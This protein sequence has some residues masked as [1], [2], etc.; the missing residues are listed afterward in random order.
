MRFQQEKTKTWK[1]ELDIIKLIS[2][3]ATGITQHA[4]IHLQKRKIEAI[5]PVTGKTVLLNI[6]VISQDGV[7]FVNITEMVQYS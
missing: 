6:K 7:Y 4:F 5:L 1:L 3:S 2:L